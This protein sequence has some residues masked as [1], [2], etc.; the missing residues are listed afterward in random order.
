MATLR[1]MVL[2]FLHPSNGNV[3]INMHSD[4]LHSMT[5]PFMASFQCESFE[6]SCIRAARDEM[7]D[8]EIIYFEEESAGDCAPCII[9]N[10]FVEKL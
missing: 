4:Q 10:S 1:M 5:S 8:C 7:G 2:L 3:A 9:Q 6:N